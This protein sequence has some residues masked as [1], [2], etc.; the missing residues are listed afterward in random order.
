MLRIIGF[1]G[2]LN[3]V[4]GILEDLIDSSA[5]RVLPL[6]AQRLWR[7]REGRQERLSW[8]RSATLD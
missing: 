4:K 3:S 6:A 7:N 1:Y 2:D 5:Y 8:C